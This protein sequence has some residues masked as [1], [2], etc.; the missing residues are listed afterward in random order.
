MDAARN[1]GYVTA[2]GAL[3]RVALDGQP[4]INTTEV[5]RLE[6][7]EIGVVSL[8]GDRENAYVTDVR[9][10]SLFNI[11][12][13]KKKSIKVGGNLGKP[14]GVT[15]D[16]LGNAYVTSGRE[17]LWRVSPGYV[18]RRFKSQPFRLPHLRRFAALRARLGMKITIG[19]MPLTDPVTCGRLI[20]FHRVWFKGSPSRNFRQE[21]DRALRYHVVHGRGRA[22]RRSQ[23]SDDEQID[24]GLGLS[25]CPSR[26]PGG[27]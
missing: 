4:G 9:G 15:L 27:E 23:Q 26:S 25:C 1:F 24:K 11:D 16:S 2:N 20:K 5:A 3:L 19:S 8:D 6:T 22:G 17:I 13:D 14:I 21:H 18:H 12:L 10:G 7:D